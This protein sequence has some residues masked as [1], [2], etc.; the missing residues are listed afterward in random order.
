LN[1][2]IQPRSDTAV[3][4]AR[5]AR[6][7]GGKLR[8]VLLRPPIV[9]TVN[10]LNNE[11]TPAIAFAYISA[12]L[13]KHGYDPIMV[14][15]IGE[16]LNRV[17]PVAQFPGYQCQGLTFDEML[18]RVP[19]GTDV[20]GLSGMFSGEWPLLRLLIEE[21]RRR[22]PEALLVVGGEHVTA[23]T[24]FSLRDCQ[25]IDLC[26][27]GEGEHKFL[28]L[29]EAAEAGEAID[30]IG[31]LGFLD[32]EGSYR[33]TAGESRIREINSIPWPEWPEGYLE[34][35]WAAGKSYGPQT[36][37]DMPM[38]FSRG[39]PFQCT[40]CSN[41]QMWTTRYT[42]RDVDDV[43]AE[44]R[45]WV[46]RYAI[47]GVQLYDLTAITKQRWARELLTKLIAGGIRVKWAFPS[48]TRSEALDFETLSLLKEAGCNY[49]AVAPESGSQRFLERLKKKIHLDKITEVIVDAKKAGLVVRANI[50]IGFP[51]ET[52]ADVYRTLLYGLKLSALG[53]DEIQPNLYS[54]Y[55]G[56]ELFDQLWSQ[57]KLQLGDAY[58]L[59]LT[60]LNSDLT[61]T[62]PLTFNESMDS[63]ELAF[64]RFVFTAL[65]YG[66]GYL[67]YPKRILRTV[68]NLFSE[69]HATTVF[70]HR[71]KDALK[72]RKKRAVQ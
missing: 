48:G 67:F 45:H 49:L 60:S 11:A 59:G 61:T 53:V 69:E 62:R 24:E 57:G 47:T 14:D 8:V 18:D 1:G 23:L 4:L 38:M 31:G 27:R 55:P 5:L 66:L 65:N 58:F 56:S 30:H 43:I 71:L 29:L 70:E 51:G 22:F 41:P 34:K 16:G 64:Y 3:R 6:P 7:D 15:A 19:A 52:R 17:W 37:R 36:D 63:R 28:A 42:L 40:F 2:T 26:V 68:S 9:S 10:A 32:A 20:I 13:R 72:R 25:A 12:Y 35:F 50:I 33:Q 44:V 54:P 46:D 21:T 39:C